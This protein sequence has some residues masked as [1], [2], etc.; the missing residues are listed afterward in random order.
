LDFGL[1]TPEKTMRLVTCSQTCVNATFL[2]RALASS[3][4]REW[5]SCH[6]ERKA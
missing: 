3:F 1:D 6:S 4:A 5:E 2:L